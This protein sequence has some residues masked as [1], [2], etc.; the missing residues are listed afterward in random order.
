MLLAQM[1]PVRIRRLDAIFHFSIKPRK[2]GSKFS[3]LGH[4][5]TNMYV[6]MQIMPVKS[7]NAE[8]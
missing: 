3:A 5:N 4:I 2:S 8:I 1:A 7:T 6:A